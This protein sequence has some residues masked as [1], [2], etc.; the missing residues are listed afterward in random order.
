MF[1]QLRVADAVAGIER[2][3]DAGR[4][5][6]FVVVDDVGLAQ[7]GADFRHH[8]IDRRAVVELR[9]HDD[10]LVAAVAARGVGSAD[11][12]A[13]AR[14]NCLQETIPRRVPQRIVD[15]LESIEVDQ[16]QR[17]QFFGRAA[18]WRWPA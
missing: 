11:A 15:P 6:D 12:G 2:G 10:K 13:Q 5:A 14:A 9:Q 1:H 16:Q 8:G 17:D 7:M 3:T 18:P 4:N